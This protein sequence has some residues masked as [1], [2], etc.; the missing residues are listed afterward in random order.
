MDFFFLVVLALI[1]LGIVSMIVS[2]ISGGGANVVMLPI[3]ILAF[4]LSPGEA[5]GT[6]FLALILGS[7][8][9]AVRFLKGGHLDI[10]RGLILGAAIIP[11]T[12]LGSLISYL[13]EGIPLEIP[14]GIVVIGLAI[15]MVVQDKRGNARQ[16]D[17]AE[18][19]VADRPVRLGLGSILLAFIGIFVGFSGQGGGLILVPTLSYIGFP[20]MTALGTTRLIAII[21]GG[22]ILFSRLALSQV[23]LFYGVALAAG[24]ITGGFLGAELSSKLRAGPLKL[25]TALLIGVLGAALALSPF[26]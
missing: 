21:G 25:F 24:T 3:L 17:A 13:S 14:L 20:I 4:G 10:K 15:M 26:L 12:L 16:G 22:T 8:A 1:A 11:G 5:I 19:G 2:T 23:N 18:K 9:A 7:I 6:A